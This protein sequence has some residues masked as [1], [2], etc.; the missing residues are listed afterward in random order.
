MTMY[1]VSYTNLDNNK[2][3]SFEFVGFGDKAHYTQLKEYIRLV[4]KC[5]NIIVTF[6]KRKLHA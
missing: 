4:H 5:P 2:I 3:R 1:H 6:M